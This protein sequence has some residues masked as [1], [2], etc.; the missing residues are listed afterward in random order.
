MNREKDAP[1]HPS[2]TYEPMDERLG[3]VWYETFVRPREDQRSVYQKTMQPMKRP[4]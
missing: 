3:P 4:R 2:D 1:R